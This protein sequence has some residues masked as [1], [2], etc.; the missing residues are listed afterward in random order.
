MKEDLKK[1]EE[2]RR[3][4]PDPSD[5]PNKSVNLSGSVTYK[6]ATTKLNLSELLSKFG[7]HKTAEAKPDSSYTSS[8]STTVEKF[9]K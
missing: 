8:I 4:M 7:Q 2:A 3:N 9:K 6:G 1:L 5:Y